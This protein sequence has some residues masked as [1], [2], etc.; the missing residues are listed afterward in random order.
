MRELCGKEIK[1]RMK[2]QPSR[3]RGSTKWSYK[4]LVPNKD[5]FEKAFNIEAGS[6]PF[7][8]KKLPLDD[9]VGIFGY[10][11]A[12]VGIASKIP[13]TNRSDYRAVSLQ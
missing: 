8:L 10:I 11:S 3:K 1:K 13:D 12:S 7:K 4:G 9:F 5:V 2:W 6:K